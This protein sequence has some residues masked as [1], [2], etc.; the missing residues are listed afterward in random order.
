M[1]AGRFDLA[2]SILRDV[3]PAALPRPGSALLDPGFESPE[4]EPREFGWHVT[5]SQAARVDFVDDVV[6]EG[7]RSV[8][9]TY[10]AAGNRALDHLKTYALVVPGSRYRLSFRWKT[11]ALVSMNTTAVTVTDATGA[12]IG[13]KSF[14]VPAGDHPWTVAEIEFVA[15]ASGAV[16]IMVTRPRCSIETDCPV[17]G[18]VWLDGFAVEAGV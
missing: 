14:L 3:D 17:F 11:A 5:S 9:I 2:A 16:S 18:V 10:E 1:K 6:A 13:A 4:G 7:K 8:R 15:P 12:T